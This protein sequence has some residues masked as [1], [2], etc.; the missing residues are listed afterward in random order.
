MCRGSKLPAP[1]WATISSLLPAAQASIARIIR[2]KGNIEPIVTKITAPPPSKLA[3]RS[4]PPREMRPLHQPGVGDRPRQPPRQRHPLGVGDGVDP[5]RAAAA[6]SLAQ[7]IATSPGAAPVVTTTSGRSRR[8]MAVIWR[9][10]VAKAS[11]FLR[12][13]FRTA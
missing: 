12:V 3:P 6:E 2:S 5:D 11:R 7:A 4:G 1:I 13:T 9:T 8:T 10:M